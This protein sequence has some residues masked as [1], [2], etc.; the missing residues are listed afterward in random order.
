VC[1][2]GWG[3]GGFKEKVVERAR[4]RNNLDMGPEPRLNVCVRFTLAM[5]DACLRAGG[6]PILV[7]LLACSAPAAC[8]SQGPP[9]TRQ[10]W[11]G[12][13]S[14]TSPAGSFCGTSSADPC[15]PA[16]AASAANSVAV[17]SLTTA[18][19]ACLSHLSTLP[20]GRAAIRQAASAV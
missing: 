13:S 8:L 7:K 4:A 3:G 12:N 11:P 14:G 19:L 16:L 9:L 15:S 18:A 1:G 2:G 20:A 5:Q 10:L 17:S 6:V